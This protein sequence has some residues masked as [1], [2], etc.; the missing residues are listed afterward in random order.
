MGGD[1]RG[2]PAPEPLVGENKR[3][4]RAKDDKR[5]NDERKCSRPFTHVRS[6]V[7]ELLIL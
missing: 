6:A 4:E 7:D 3:K 5:H 2:A 1:A